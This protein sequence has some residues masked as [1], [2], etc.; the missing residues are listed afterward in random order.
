MKVRRKSSVRNFEINKYWYTHSELFELAKH[1]LIDCL[2]IDGKEV[3]NHDYDSM[4]DA[5]FDNAYFVV[6]ASDVDKVEIRYSDDYECY[7]TCA[8]DRYNREFKIVV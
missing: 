1:G 8:V 6:Y 3:Y 4:T 2:F 5:D 7:Y